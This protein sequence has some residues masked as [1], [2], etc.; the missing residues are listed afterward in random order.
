M[1]LGQ[2]RVLKRFAGQGEDQF[3]GQFLAGGIAIGGLLL[4]TVHHDALEPRGDCQARL[5]ERRRILA[6]DRAQRLDWC[7]ALERPLSGQHLVQDDAE[8]EQV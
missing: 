7:V 1:V 4:Q 8:R 2:R 3:V 6:Q 5:G